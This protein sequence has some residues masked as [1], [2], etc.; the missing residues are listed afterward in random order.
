MDKTKLTPKNKFVFWLILL[1]I[2]LAIVITLIVFSFV[3]IEE[4]GLLSCLFVGIGMAVLI[5]L[6]VYT[7]LSGI[8]AYRD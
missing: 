2:S 6:S 1:L 5:V 7:T 8:K 3:F 4:L